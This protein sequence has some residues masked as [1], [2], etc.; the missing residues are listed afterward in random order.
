MNTRNNDQRWNSDL[1]PRLPPDITTTN[2]TQRKSDAMKILNPESKYTEHITPPTNDIKLNSR[3]KQQ[4]R[5][6]LTCPRRGNHTTYR[7]WGWYQNEWKTRWGE[8]LH[9]DVRGPNTFVTTMID[10]SPEQVILTPKVL[11][12][13]R[14]L[15][16]QYW[17]KWNWHHILSSHHWVCYDLNCGMCY[18][19]LHLYAQCHGYRSEDSI[20]AMHMQ[21]GWQQVSPAHVELCPKPT[22]VYYVPL[23]LWVL[24]GQLH[25]ALHLLSV[26]P[27]GHGEF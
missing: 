21:P 5:P 11:K 14:L 23:K 9:P 20:L 8:I 19:C 2:P 24:H 7:K 16:D 17:P 4:D 12:G 26:P 15:M 27:L 22:L 25:T 1:R 10:E 13:N 6:W 18:H 3:H